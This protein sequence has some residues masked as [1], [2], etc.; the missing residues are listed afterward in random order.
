MEQSE[1]ILQDRK[2]PRKSESYVLLSIPPENIIKPEVYRK[3][4]C[5]FDMGL[6][7]DKITLSHVFFNVF[8]LSVG[9]NI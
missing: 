8:F 9:R 2:N 6:K 3:G 4:T 7:P 5:V 1:V